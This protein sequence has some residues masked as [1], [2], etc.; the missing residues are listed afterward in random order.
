[1]LLIKG[2]R[3]NLVLSLA[4]INSYRF[5]LTHMIMDL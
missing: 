1:M 5:I 4:G 2:V 3:T